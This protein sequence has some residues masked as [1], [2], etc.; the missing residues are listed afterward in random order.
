MTSACHCRGCQKMTASAFSLSALFLSE[1]MAVE[2]QT[3]IGGL[4]GPEQRHHHCAHCLAWLF[5]RFTGMDEIVNV[6]AS[7]FEDL[8][9]FTPFLETAT[10]EKLAWVTLPAGRSYSGFPPDSEFPELMKDYAAETSHA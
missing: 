10:A 1:A 3:V 6:R 5:T 4:H 2:G 8:T 9:W 7:V